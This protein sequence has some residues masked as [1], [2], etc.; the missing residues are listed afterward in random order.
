MGT[1]N[2][3]KYAARTRSDLCC[4]FTVVGQL[5]ILQLAFTSSSICIIKVLIFAGELLSPA[6]GFSAQ[7]KLYGV[8]HA[9][10]I[11]FWRG[12]PRATCHCLFAYSAGSHNNFPVC[13][14]IYIQVAWSS[15]LFGAY[16][17]LF[18]SF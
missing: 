11:T 5:L 17:E 1:K 8:N 10:S 9:G 3:G 15:D 14:I 2:M 6:S 4:L 16:G 13:F 7:C 12:L 18:F